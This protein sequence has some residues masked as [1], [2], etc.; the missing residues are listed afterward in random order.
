M[1]L[2]TVKL[3]ISLMQFIDTLKIIFPVLYQIHKTLNEGHL[4]YQKFSHISLHG[5]YHVQF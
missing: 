3:Y 5:F 4:F 2:N 1:P